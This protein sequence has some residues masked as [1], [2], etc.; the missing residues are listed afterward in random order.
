MAQPVFFDPRQA[1]WKRLRWLFDALAVSFMLLV[2]FFI[3]NVLH[4]EPLPTLLWKTETK[5]YHALRESEREKAKERRRQAALKRGQ[6]RIP[7][8]PS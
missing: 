5:P 6:R 1:R 3:Y 8:L 7:G 4:D 2:S